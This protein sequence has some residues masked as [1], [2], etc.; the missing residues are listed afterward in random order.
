MRKIRLCDSFAI[1]IYKQKTNILVLFRILHTKELS[2]H[3]DLRFLL[4]HHC[5]DT[6]IS[7]RCFL[8]AFFF[9]IRTSSIFSCVVLY[10]SNSTSTLI[11]PKKYIS[12]PTG[13]VVFMIYEELFLKKYKKSQFPPSSFSS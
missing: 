13:K 5:Y 4:H 10:I 8:F 9:T 11:S 2:H 7:L 3:H 6:I 12:N 1:I